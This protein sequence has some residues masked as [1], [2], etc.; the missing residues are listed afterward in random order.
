MNFHL[1]K[2]YQYAHL[3]MWFL[4][5]ISALPQMLD[6]EIAHFGD[7]RKSVETNIAT[8]DKQIEMFGKPKDPAKAAKRLLVAIY[9]SLQVKENWNKP[10][11]KVGKQ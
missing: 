6:S 2:P 3:K 1:T 10:L 9:E 4:E 7:V 11:E 8:I 5:N